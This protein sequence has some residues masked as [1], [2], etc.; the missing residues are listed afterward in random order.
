MMTSFVVISVCFCFLAAVNLDIDRGWPSSL[1]TVFY[2]PR[3]LPLCGLPK[4]WF[5]MFWLVILSTITFKF[6]FS[7]SIDNN[8]IDK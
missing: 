6:L 8:K 5:M 2:R 4:E 7:I 1:D 3:C